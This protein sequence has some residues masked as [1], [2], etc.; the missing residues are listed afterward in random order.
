MNIAQM[1]KCLTA[2]ISVAYCV[3]V[4]RLLVAQTELCEVFDKKIFP[5]LTCRMNDGAFFNYVSSKY[6]TKQLQKGCRAYD[7]SEFYPWLD[8]LFLLIIIAIPHQTH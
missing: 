3:V 4:H 1:Q 2:E 8:S 6:T 7:L 5:T